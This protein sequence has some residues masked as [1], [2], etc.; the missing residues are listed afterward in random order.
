[1][2]SIVGLDTKH[3]HQTSCSG[4]ASILEYTKSEIQSIKVTD[5]AGWSETVE[6]IQCPKCGHQV[7]IRIL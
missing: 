4:C 2:V 1:M 3:V 7:S 6:C 5:Y